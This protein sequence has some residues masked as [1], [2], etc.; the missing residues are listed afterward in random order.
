MTSG[1][2][3]QASATNCVLPWPRCSGFATELADS[4]DGF[5]PDEARDWSD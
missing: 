3:W 2:S 1:T 4:W 5:E